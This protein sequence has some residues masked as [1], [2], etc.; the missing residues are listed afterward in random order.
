MRNPMIGS[1]PSGTPS[2][3][4]MRLSPHPT[5][6]GSSRAGGSDGSGAV[7]SSIG[8]SIGSM[9]IVRR[10]S[11]ISVR[12]PFSTDLDNGCRLMLL[13]LDL[14]DNPS[15]VRRIPDEVSKKGHADS[16]I[17]VTS[18]GRPEG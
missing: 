8:V 11:P 13:P 15:L 14:V 4:V 7:G 6:S 18:S 2:H 12:H 9:K 1:I 5:R 16:V 3:V 17:R 10:R